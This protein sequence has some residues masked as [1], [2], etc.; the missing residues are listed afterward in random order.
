MPFVF[1]LPLKQIYFIYQYGVVVEGKE[2]KE[3]LDNY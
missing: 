1:L 3:G 2:Q